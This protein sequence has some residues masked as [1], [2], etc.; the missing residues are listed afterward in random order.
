[1]SRAVVN[2]QHFVRGLRVVRAKVLRR[3]DY[4]HC[5]LMMIGSSTM[6]FV[7]FNQS[8]L[9]HLMLVLH[10]VVWESGNEITVHIAAT[11]QWRNGAVRI[12]FFSTSVH[13]C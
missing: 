10:I 13:W 2:Q 12:G 3:R 11:E 7:V 4:R 6:S 5:A 1:M 9:L 8:L